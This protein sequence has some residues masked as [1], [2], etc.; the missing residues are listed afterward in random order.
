[1]RKEGSAA[2]KAYEK[3]SACQRKFDGGIDAPNTLI[4]AYKAYKQTDPDDAAR[5]LTDAINLFIAQ[6]SFRRAA[7][8]QMD[9]G[10]VYENDLDN[11]TWAIKAYEKAGEWYYED[12][13][14]A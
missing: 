7:G 14:E 9:L 11:A 8:F 13:A 2:G 3:A 10:A 5:V 12:Q 4:E 1:M 6:G